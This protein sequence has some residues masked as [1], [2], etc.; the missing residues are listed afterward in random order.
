MVPAPGEQTHPEQSEQ[1]G[2]RC[3]WRLGG[4]CDDS[5]CMMGPWKLAL[6]RKPG[7]FP[8]G[9]Q[10]WLVNGRG[11][12]HCILARGCD[13]GWGGGGKLLRAKLQR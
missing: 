12:R 5:V 2:E 3:I 8:A 9:D 6:K 13:A 4:E 11:G 10:V 7:T 1:E